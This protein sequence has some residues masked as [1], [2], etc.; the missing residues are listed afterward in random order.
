MNKSLVF[1]DSRIIPVGFLECYVANISDR[2]EDKD[3]HLTESLMKQIK[4]SR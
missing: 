2:N 1:L 4:L 3:V